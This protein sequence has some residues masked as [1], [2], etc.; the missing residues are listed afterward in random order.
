MEILDKY[1]SF[2]IPGSLPNLNTVLNQT[3]AHW[4]NYNSEK[5][6]WNTIICYTIKSYKFKK[7]E[8]TEFPLKVRFIWYSKNDKFDLDNICFAKKYILDGMKL[9]GLIPDDS[10]RYINGFQDDC[11][12]ADRDYV[13]VHFFKDE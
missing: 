12:I 5:I 8:L 1:G 7:I 2:E 10:R 3:K 11:E 6:E 4:S 13:K 9:S